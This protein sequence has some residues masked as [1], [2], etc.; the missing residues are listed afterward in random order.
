MNN[1]Q[2]R[3]KATDEA[4]CSSC[5]AIIKK[6]AE[7]CLKCGVRQKKTGNSSDISDNWLTCL[8]LCIFLGG[9]G[10][11]RFYT[12]KTGTAILM[13]FTLGGFGIWTLID[14]IMILTEKFSDS[15]GNIITRNG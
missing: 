8:L 3:E 14:L 2:F 15:Q 12:G 13:L 9:F 6:E 1:S 5:G 10:G 11:H 4:F 7:I